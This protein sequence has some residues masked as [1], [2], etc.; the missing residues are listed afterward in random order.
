MPAEKSTYRPESQ[1]AGYEK[2]QA[3]ADRKRK[4]TKISVLCP[5]IWYLP[6]EGL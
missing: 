2:I 1:N 4:N 3:Q 5:P 6:L